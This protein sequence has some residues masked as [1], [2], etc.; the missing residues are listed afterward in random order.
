MTARSGTWI[1]RMERPYACGVSAS[2]IASSKNATQAVAAAIK[3]ISRFARA[4][5][6]LSQTRR[7]IAARVRQAAATMDQMIATMFIGSQRYDDYIC[8]INKLI[9]QAFH[10]A[11]TLLPA[12]NRIIVPASRRHLNQR[13]A[14]NLE[15]LEE[16][17]KSRPFI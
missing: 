4:V 8:A 1:H 9:L 16:M 11:S 10:F 7:F 13:A 3:A 5:R 6:L 2:I 14:V 12:T 17:F 15:E